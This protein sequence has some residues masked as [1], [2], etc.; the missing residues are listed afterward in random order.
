[1]SDSKIYR[2][3]LQIV[4]PRYAF[5]GIAAAASAAVLVWALVAPTSNKA[6]AAMDWREYVLLASCSTIFLAA[7]IGQSLNFRPLR[8]NDCGIASFLF[9]FR[10]R[11]IPWSKTEKIEKVRIYD[12]GTNTYWTVYNV[13][14]KGRRTRIRFTDRLCNIEEFLSRVNVYV[15]EHEIPLEFV[16]R[17]RDTRMKILSQALDPS[18]RRKIMKHGLRTTINA[19]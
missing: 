9:G 2:Y 1:M 15:S 7:M 13:R 16:D 3:S 6:F 12:T 18:E 10:F 14:A 19:L 17:G 11:S 5:L 8:V 4:A